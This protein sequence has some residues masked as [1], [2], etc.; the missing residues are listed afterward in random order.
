MNTQIEKML[1]EVSKLES[2]DISSVLGG[3]NYLLKQTAI[4]AAVRLLPDPPPEGSGIEYFTEWEQK[5][6]NPEIKTRCS[7]LVGLSQRVEEVL[8]QYVDREPQTFEGV[9]KFMTERPP[10]RA[11]FEA[12]YNNRKRLGMKPAMTMK[13]FVDME[14]KTALDRQQ[15][16]V[17]RGEDAIRVLHAVEGTDEEV[18]EWLY[19]AIDNKV[20]QKLEERWKRHDLRATNT[21]VTQ[22]DRDLATANK[23]L[24]AACMEALGGKA[25]TDPG[26]G[27]E[28]AEKAQEDINAFLIRKQ[29][30]LDLLV[31]QQEALKQHNE[32][33]K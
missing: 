6:R 17:A 23:K 19:E 30:E 1:T 27:E 2:W 13:E 26:T 29:E 15:M 8:N 10:Q 28:A 21:R 12:D 25:P 14:Y 5:M 18:P 32:A 16:L 9:L 4:N 20:L 33:R 7:P 22:S 24:V 31:M 11:T 3:V